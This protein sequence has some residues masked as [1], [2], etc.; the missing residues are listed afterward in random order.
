MIAFY[1][2]LKSSLYSFLSFFWHHRLWLSCDL[3]WIV[4][5]PCWLYEWPLVLFIPSSFPFFVVVLLVLHPVLIV[6]TCH[7]AVLISVFSFLSIFSCLIKFMLWFVKA[8]VCLAAWRAVTAIS[9]CWYLPRVLLV[10]SYPCPS[11]LSCPLINT[12]LLA[13]A[14]HHLPCDSCRALFSF[15]FQ[16]WKGC[17]PLAP[18]LLPLFSCHRSLLSISPSLLIIHV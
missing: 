1:P 11:R 15:Y 12:K 9:F 18:F 6:Y 10:L 2:R 17:V 13:R 7:I 14:H 3:L 16:S 8:F 4:Q 5:L